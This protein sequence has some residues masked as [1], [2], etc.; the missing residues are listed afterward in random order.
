[1]NEEEIKQLIAKNKELEAKLAD[2]TQ[3]PKHGL[4]PVTWNVL[5]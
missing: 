2:L 5:G 1:M 4:D 3:K